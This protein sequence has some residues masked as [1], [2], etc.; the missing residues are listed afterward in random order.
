MKTF[1]VPKEIG[2]GQFF[3]YQTKTP[4]CA[5]GHLQYHFETA[6]DR[7]MLECMPTLAK[8]LGIHEDALD[9]LSIDNDRTKSQD[10][11]E[12]RR[13]LNAWLRTLF[14]GQE[15]NIKRDGFIDSIRK[16]R[17]IHGCSLTEAHEEATRLRAIEEGK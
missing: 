9:R 14:P 3:N 8:S 15:I 2:W 6:M 4:S 1:V 13:I 17:T 12:R 11:E 5:V 16:I 7:P 10:N